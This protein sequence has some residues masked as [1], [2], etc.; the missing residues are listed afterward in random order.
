MV[1]GSR[2][3]FLMSF[4]QD[5]EKRDPSLWLLPPI[6]AQEEILLVE[7]GGTHREEAGRFG[8]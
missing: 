6:P 5:S 7:T 8:Q 3:C 4:I 2:K 1:K